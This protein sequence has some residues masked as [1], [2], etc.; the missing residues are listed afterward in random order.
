LGLSAVRSAAAPETLDTPRTPA[1]SSAVRLPRPRQR[2]ARV[3]R[4]AVPPCG[5]LRPRERW[6]PRIPAP[7]P[8]YSRC[9][10]GNP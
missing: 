1:P 9:G 4:P 3:P 7:A 5:R 6:A 8:P 10:P 2:W